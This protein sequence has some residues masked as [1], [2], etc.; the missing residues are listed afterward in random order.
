MLVNLSTAPKTQDD[1]K[2]AEELMQS[3]DFESL[4]EALRLPSL[5]ADRSGR[6]VATN[7]AARVSFGDLPEGTLVHLRFRSPELRQA[8]ESVF[9][10]AQAQHCD[11]HV[12]VPDERWYRV[13]A[14]PLRDGDHPMRCFL[15][16]QDVSES[17]KIDQMRAD[18]IANAS[19]ELRTPLAS[20][21][22]FIETLLGPAKDDAKARERFLPIMQ[23]QAGRMSRLID[24][25]LSL[26]RLEMRPFAN[27][28][29]RMDLSVLLQSI[30]D[31]FQPKADQAGVGIE[32]HLGQDAFV[33]SGIR[34]ELTQAFE[35]LI[36]NAVKYG[37]SG[38]RVLVSLSSDAATGDVLFSVQDFG[39]GIATTDLPRLTERFYR[40]ESGHDRSIKGTGLGLA[41]VKH[42]VQR[43]QGQL[44]IHSVPGEGA[45]FTIRLKRL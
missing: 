1:D 33:V 26:S 36:E 23:D 40:S 34:D 31:G 2:V 43:H 19:H 28:T 29:E 8:I 13:E 11:Y 18:F 32:M 16:F 37:R 27:L 3:G 22:G 7:P 35:N 12:R 5:L 14:T 25:L 41:I 30:I 39:P 45:T 21:A 10:T 42:I 4:T 20:L 6:L 15:L 44:S 24:D 17:R 9:Q 38:E